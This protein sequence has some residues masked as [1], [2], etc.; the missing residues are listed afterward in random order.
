MVDLSCPAPRLEGGFGLPDP[1]I[2]ECLPSSPR[3][4]WRCFFDSEK[5][6]FLDVFDMYLV[7]FVI[8]RQYVVIFSQCLVNILSSLLIPP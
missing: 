2:A 3:V 8:F 7:V 6:T 5:M 4:V 1:P